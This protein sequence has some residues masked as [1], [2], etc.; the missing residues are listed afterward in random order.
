MKKFIHRRE[1][2]LSAPIMI[3]LE[4]A[5]GCNMKC[6][7]CYNFWREENDKGDKIDK[8]KFDIILDKIIEAKVFH[9]VLTGGEPFVNFDVLE[10][11]IKKLTENNISS[12]VNSNLTLASPEKVKRLS[13]AGLDHILTSI[14]SHI[15]E[16]NDKVFNS[17]GALE[18]L[19]NGIKNSVAGG[20]RVSA[21]MVISENN[22][23]DIYETGRL[24]AELGVQ[25]LFST[26]LVP[27]VNVKK[28]TEKEIKLSKESALEALDE[29]LRVKKDF[30]IAVGSLISYPLCLLGDLEKYSDFIGRGCPAY[31]GNRMVVNADG[32]VH[33]CTHEEVDYGNVFENSITEIFKKM[34]KWHDGS[35][36]FEGCK[37]CPY[38]NVCNSGCRSAAL[39]YFKKIEA[40]DPL[41][42]GW[43]SIK[44]KISLD[45]PKDIENLVDEN[46]DFIVPDTIRFRK[47][48]GFYTIN[49]RWANAFDIDTESAEFLLDAQKNKRKLNRIDFEEK[50]TRKDMIELIYKEALIPADNSLV[51]KLNGKVGCSINPKDLVEL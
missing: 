44:N 5:S 18:K 29:M 28:P 36:L 41:Y 46:E 19:K 23:D 15:S 37:T 33:A 48:N 6:V 14:N 40:K 2:I 51:E 9:V 49:I 45:I 30:D 3:N 16:K 42:T 47:E 20:I 50:F 4:I 11:G 43:K 32:L 1:R 13:A 34:N 22:K 10:Y 38:I 17:K 39:G 31:R 7:H 12:S 27:S 24:C 8:E 35:Y 26:R 21:N 25:K